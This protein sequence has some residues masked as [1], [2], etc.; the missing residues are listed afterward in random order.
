MVSRQYPPSLRGWL[1]R[2]LPRHSK[3]GDYQENHHAG[4]EQQQTRSRSLRL[5]SPRCVTLKRLRMCTE[6]NDAELSRVLTQEWDHTMVLASLP[7]L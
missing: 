5:L 7:A 1:G 3:C 2:P 4:N 6:S